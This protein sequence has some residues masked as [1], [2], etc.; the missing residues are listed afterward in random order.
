MK[1]SALFTAALLSSVVASNAFAQGETGSPAAKEGA[2]FWV[3]HDVLTW[4]NSTREPDGSAKVKENSLQTNPDDISIAIYW[5]NMGLYVEPGVSNGSNQL[6]GLSLFPQKEVEIG[7]KLGLNHK[8]VDNGG[9]TKTK[10]EAFGIFGNYYYQLDAISSLEFGAEY[11]Y[12][13]TKVEED[14]AVDP[15]TGIRAPGSDTTN[16]GNVLSIGVQYAYQIAEH[17]H[18]VPGIFF[19][20]G[21]STVDTAAGDSDTDATGLKINLA[22]FRYVF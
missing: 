3:Q 21:K 12:D 6:V 14:G 8:T 15:V 2:T 1:N 17:F 9:E 20:T 22:K 18:V 19:N 4:S 5:K 13:K 11:I 7:V 10:G 16:K